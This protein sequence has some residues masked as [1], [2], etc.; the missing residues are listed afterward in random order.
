MVNTCISCLN[1]ATKKYNDIF[2]CQ[3][4]FDM[5]INMMKSYEYN[6]NVEYSSPTFICDN[7][8]IGNINSVSDYDKLKDFGIQKIIIA[9]SGLLN[10]VNS[11]F[12][13]IELLID[14]SLEQNI[15]PHIDIALN[16]INAYR[17]DKILIHCC[18]GISRSATI[19]LAYLIRKYNMSFSDAETFLK[20]KYIKAK[21]NSNFV[22]QLKL[23]N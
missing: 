15:V 6:N 21:P 14:D 19:I 5:M 9:G 23:L 13:H 1:D 18:S 3:E 4:C 16:F 2:L 8:Y 17:D 22:S 11:R 20:S 7:I 10:K 12:Q